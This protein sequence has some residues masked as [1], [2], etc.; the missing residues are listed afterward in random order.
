LA[1]LVKVFSGFLLLAMAIAVLILNM[2]YNLR[3]FIVILGL[4]VGVCGLYLII[5]STSNQIITFGNE[6]QVLGKTT[7][8]KDRIK[9]LD[10]E[11]LSDNI[12]INLKRP[13]F[14]K[15]K[16]EDMDSLNFEDLENSGSYRSYDDY[17]DSDDEDDSK[18]VLKVQNPTS[19]FTDKTYQFTPNYERPL[20]ITRKPTK[21][22]GRSNG[23]LNIS[24]IP[25][26]KKSEKIEEVLAENGHNSDSV[27][28]NTDFEDFVNEDHSRELPNN[29]E[30]Y[31]FYNDNPLNEA[32]IYGSPFEL[33]NLTDLP[34]N[35]DKVVS[36]N[37]IP[38]TITPI[39]EDEIEIDPNNPE[40]LPIPKL[41]RSYVISSN[42]RISTQEAFD[43]LS[44]NAVN[45]ICLI[46]SSLK[47]L[48]H[49]FLEN[50]SNIPTKI[51]IE[52]ID[53]ADLSE[54]LILNSIVKKNVEIR[55]MPKLD[56][57]NLI[58]DDD[59]ALIVSD[60]EEDKRFQYGAVYTDKTSIDDIRNMF[61]STW[62][63]AHAVNSQVLAHA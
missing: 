47:D 58:I 33:S 45:E 62:N 16:I 30:D 27:V 7:S 28:Y 1:D 18:L 55:T 22:E 59:Y 23:L 19:K 54:A 14:E 61:D 42:G 9:N 5:T 35:Q 46:T 4:I 52:D 44:A 40:S 15:T 57:I 3:E 13:K 11:G 10:V 48:S 51:I 26:S 20:K 56:T 17:E 8:T 2:F 41:L 37:T 39:K 36:P 12:N 49:E 21:K 63:I 32:N 53:T 31:G 25:K 38:D 24:N 43:K 34:E 50:I 6:N 29:D 60:S